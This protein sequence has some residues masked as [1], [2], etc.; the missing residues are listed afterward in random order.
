LDAERRAAARFGDGIVQVQDIDLI[1][2]QPRQAAFERLRHGLG[3]AAEVGG[4]QPDL[5]ADDHIGGFERLQ[6][7]AEILLGFTVAVLHG[8]IEV[9]HADG[10]RPRHGAL[11]V[12]RIAAHHQSTDRAAAE[13]QHRKLH[14]AAAEYPHVHRSSS[15]CMPQTAQHTRR[16][17]GVETGARVRWLLL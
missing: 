13:A 16:C 1:A 17:A 5:G 10:D 2:A 8:G 6:D 11:L 4:R 7:A 12:A 15:A 14:S 9:I 3:N